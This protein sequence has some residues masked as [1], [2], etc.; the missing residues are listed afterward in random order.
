MGRIAGICRVVTWGSKG[1]CS[2][3]ML[4]SK[5]LD[6][7]CQRTAPSLSPTRSLRSPVHMMPCTDGYRKV[8]S[9]HAAQKMPTTRPERQE[10]HGQACFQ[11]ANSE[12]QNW[13]HWEAMSPW[14]DKITAIVWAGQIK[15]VP[16]SLKA[17]K[18]IWQTLD[19]WGTQ[20]K[21]KSLP[22]LLGRCLHPTV[23]PTQHLKMTRA[24]R[25]CDCQDSIFCTAIKACGPRPILT[26]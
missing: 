10:S 9:T 26:E 25:G 5:A 15:G 21:T 8:S 24:G 16:S 6:W 18:G 23:T 14:A 11:V 2:P 4:S 19:G 12:E 3:R 13:A 20:H 17:A 7:D 1:A 22:A